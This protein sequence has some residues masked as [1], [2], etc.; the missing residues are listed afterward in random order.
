MVICVLCNGV[1]NYQFLNC[2]GKVET[3]EE[4][5]VPRRLEAKSLLE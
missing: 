4:E 3:K 2:G 1:G 5:K